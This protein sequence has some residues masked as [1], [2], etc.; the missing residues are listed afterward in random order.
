MAKVQCR[1]KR[2][3]DGEFYNGVYEVV[4]DGEVA[5]D[6]SASRDWKRGDHWVFDP[7]GG[8]RVWAYTKKE[9]LAELKA[10]FA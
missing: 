3:G 7:I 10:R 5:G 9:M 4:V 8:K 1:R 6:L 2:F